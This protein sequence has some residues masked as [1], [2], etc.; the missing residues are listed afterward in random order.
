MQH[1]PNQT[2]LNSSEYLDPWSD[3]SSYQSV[4]WRYSDTCILVLCIFGLLSSL[5]TLLTIYGNDHF[6]EPCF[7]CYIAVAVS[8][9]IY[10]ITYAFSRW[11]TLNGLFTSSYSWARFSKDRQPLFDVSVS[12][13]TILIV[14]LSLHRAVAC[15][16]PNKYYWFNTKRVCVGV[17]IFAYVAS[18]FHAVPQLFAYDYKTDN[19]TGR[20]AAIYSQF[21]LSQAYIT[22]ATVIDTYRLV[23]G[24]AHF[25]SSTLAIIGMLRAISLK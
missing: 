13:T 15:L 1:E 23:Q 10:T 4:Y 19:E 25:V 5:L 14:F 18:A 9:F 7:V 24:L 3:F 21:G 12:A 11:A 20:F 6:S 16:L 2:Y 17:V 8:E 22:Y